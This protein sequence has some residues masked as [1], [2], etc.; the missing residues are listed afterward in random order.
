MIKRRR[1]NGFTFRVCR[2]QRENQMSAKKNRSC[3]EEQKKVSERIKRYCQKVKT[4][5]VDHD[6]ISIKRGLLVV[7]PREKLSRLL[8]Q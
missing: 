3:T 4:M 6:V 2:R 5:V 7:K 1:R 8:L